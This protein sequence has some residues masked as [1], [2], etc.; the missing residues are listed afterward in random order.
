MPTN[1][2]APSVPAVNALQLL[3]EDHRRVRELFREFERAD[4]RGREP[5]AEAAMRE[6]EAHSKLE[7]Q[8][9]YPSVRG[10][11]ENPDL[12][13]RFEEAHSIVDA[14]LGE[15]KLMPS[16]ARFDAKFKLLI[17]SVEDHIREEE[18]DLFPHLEKSGVDLRT[19]GLEME[20]FKADTNM[21]SSSGGTVKG[22]I[23]A[24]AIAALGGVAMRMIRKAK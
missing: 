7:E 24:A 22:L 20:C 15:L 10:E 5:I 13:I 9:F 11:V 4:K 18:K 3:R 6:L 19:L 14:I 2:V 17:R 12:I 21:E 1:V 8:V 16:G 23:V